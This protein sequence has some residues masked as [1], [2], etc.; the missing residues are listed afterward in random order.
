MTLSLCQASSF[1]PAYGVAVSSLALS[2]G[3]YARP[4][5]QPS[6]IHYN[7]FVSGQK[8]RRLLG[9]R[10]VREWLSGALLLRY[11]SFLTIVNIYKT[12]VGRAMTGE[13]KITN[14]E[15]LY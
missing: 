12:S 9:F 8:R 14:V 3:E 13:V 5:L 6:D 7:T 10:I 1:L 4:I 15:R 11:R 2:P